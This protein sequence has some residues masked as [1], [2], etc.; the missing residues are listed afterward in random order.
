MWGE[1]MG[2]RLVHSWMDGGRMANYQCMTHFIN[3][4]GTMIEPLSIDGAWMGGEEE[5][6]AW[7]AVFD[8]CSR[9]F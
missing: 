2:D 9:F 3:I 8:S 5:C 4:H 6:A 1:Q 7:V